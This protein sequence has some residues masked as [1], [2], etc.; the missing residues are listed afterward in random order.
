MLLVFVFIYGG[1]W[2]FGDFLMYEWFVCDFVV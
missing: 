2:V 1:G